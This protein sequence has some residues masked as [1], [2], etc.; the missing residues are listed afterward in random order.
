MGWAENGPASRSPAMNVG[1]NWK[2]ATMDIL[3]IVLLLVIA[4]LYASIGHGGASGYLALMA[5]FSIDPFLMRSS[6]LILNLFV[7]GVSFFAFYSGGYFKP[8]ILL[9]FIITSIPMAF[10]GATIEIDPSLY[11]IILGLF[12]LVAVARMLFIR[13]K[14]TNK[15]KSPPFLIAMIIGAG[16]GF[17]SG[18]IGIGG[19]I[20]LSPILILLGWASL[21]EAAAVSA[22]FIFLNSASGLIGIFQTDNTGNSHIAIWIVAAFLGGLIGSFAG[23][24]KFSNIRLKYILAFILIMASIKLMMI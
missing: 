13:P 10:L 8:K 11:K 6:A 1:V 5:I 12:L 2:R 23:S 20:I 9:P 7:A 18:M 4:A 19:G 3:F 15:I 16:L 22:L 14:E 24:F 21:K 17:F